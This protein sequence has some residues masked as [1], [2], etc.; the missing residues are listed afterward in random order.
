MK[1]I[2]YNENYTELQS[3]QKKVNRLKKQDRFEEA[4]IFMPRLN[5]LLEKRRLERAEIVKRLESENSSYY[6]KYFRL[7]NKIKWATEHDVDCEDLKE[8]FEELRKGRKQYKNRKPKITN[9]EKIEKQN[10][11]DEN[12]SLKKDLLRKEVKRMIWLYKTDQMNEFDYYLLAH[13]F[14]FFF[15]FNKNDDSYPI[16]KQIKIMINKL[17]DLFTS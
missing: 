11:F 6:D 3:L 9:E 14:L 10:K 15:S 16:K 5:E 12:L 4:E 7:Y 17:E 2:E 13:Y 1:K 8:E